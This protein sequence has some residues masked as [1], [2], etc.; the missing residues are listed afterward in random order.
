[1]RENFFAPTPQASYDFGV[2]SAGNRR[3][4]ACIG[5]LTPSMGVVDARV[6]GLVATREVAVGTRFTPA[7][8]GAHASSLGRRSVVRTGG[9]SA[10]R[11]LTRDGGATATARGEGT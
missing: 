5:R 3:H 2:S 11:G 10:S 7:F 6:G 4:D 1:M 9:R 8:A